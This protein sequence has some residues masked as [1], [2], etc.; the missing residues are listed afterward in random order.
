MWCFVGYLT[1]NFQDAT[2]V[3]GTSPANLLLLAAGSFSGVRENYAALKRQALSMQ[4]SP[5]LE[6][7]SE[8][9]KAELACFDKVAMAN[10]LAAAV[11]I[12]TWAEETK[13]KAAMT[14][15][16]KAASVQRPKPGVRYDFAAHPYFFTLKIKS[17]AA[18]A[19]AKK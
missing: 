9:Q 11:L 5:V 1:E 3:D 6:A 13:E 8:Q 12:K 17:A 15:E 4:N 14:E 16:E 18:A 19:G 7:L 10:S 2:R